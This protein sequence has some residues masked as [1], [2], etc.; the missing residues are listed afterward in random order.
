MGMGLL[1]FYK[2]KY[3][4]PHY[5]DT[6]TA[7]GLPMDCTPVG[8]NFKS[9]T[10]RV[11]GDML[12]FMSCNY[13]TFTRD[14]VT[15]FAW[16]ED[17][18]FL[19]EDS[20]TVNYS[21]DAWRTYKSKI[22]L[23]K[24]FV[25]RQPSPTYKFDKFLGSEIPQPSVTTQ[26][27]NRVDDASRVFVVQVRT[28]AGDLFSRSPVNPTPY[29]FYMVKY[30]K[31]N[32]TSCQPILDLILALSNSAESI[33]IVTMYSIPY[34]DLDGLPI[35]GLVIKKGSDG[36]TIATIE[37][38]SFLGDQDPTYRL[39]LETPITL[40][41]DVLELLQVDHSVQ[42]VVP[43]AGVITIPDELLVRGDL[44]LRQDIDLFSGASNFMLVSDDGQYT[45]SVRG[46]S[47][48]SIPIVS[49]PMD[50]YLSQNQNALATSLMGDVASIA[51]GLAMGVG[52]G[53]VGGAIG[54]AGIGSGITGIMNTYASVL[55]SGSKYNNPPAFLGTALATVF[56]QKFWVVTTRTTVSNGAD[57]HDK[58]GYP[59]DIVTTLTFP[60]SGF[61]QTQG[62]TVSSTDGSVPKWAIEEINK[63][64]NDGI[65]VHTA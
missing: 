12:D 34:M 28:Q 6:I 32:W 51:G 44:K 30:S 64:F 48:S 20:F 19:T 2:N 45:R 37:G 5:S 9:G 63:N 42:L 53:G 8:M 17:V 40:D 60:S 31:N 25:A 10:L 18:Q 65:L 13:L 55:D 22:D 57:V 56:N 21:V 41:Y 16:I 4:Y 39:K 14:G 46:S 58:F 27:F 23:G 29:Q 59:L 7:Y 49:D 43:E 33:N 26:L 61:I 3:R 35:Q 54:M 50:T 38:F 62:C 11:K 1:Q 15:L 47:I 36:A 24:Q 52:T